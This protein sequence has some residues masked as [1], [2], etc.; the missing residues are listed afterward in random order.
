MDNFTF[1][2]YCIVIGFVSIWH[3]ADVLTSS[4]IQSSL[5]ANDYFLTQIGTR[6]CSKPRY[7]SYLFVLSFFILRFIAM[8]I[9]T[10]CR[11]A[12]NKIVP[13]TILNKYLYSVQK[14]NK[15]EYK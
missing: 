12:N 11:T 8:T 1:Y 5:S 15:N 10:T 3:V 9:Y 7:R 6:R 14:I 2:L 4:K 13:L